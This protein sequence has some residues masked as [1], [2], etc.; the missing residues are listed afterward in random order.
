MKTHGPKS[1][2][3]F[4]EVFTGTFFISYFTKAILSF[5]WAPGSFPWA[6]LFQKEQIQR[7]WTDVQ[8]TALSSL[9]SLLWWV[10]W[11]ECV[12]NHLPGRRK[13][14]LAHLVCVNGIC[15]VTETSHVTTSLSPN[16]LV[17]DYFN[18]SRRKACALRQWCKLLATMTKCV[19]LKSLYIPV[20]HCLFLAV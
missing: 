16:Y 9:C 19:A 14:C 15:C 1:C 2:W 7:A 12:C 5:L 10:R 17:T 6:F 4:P 11:V 3:V 20:H 13:W 8:G 18:V